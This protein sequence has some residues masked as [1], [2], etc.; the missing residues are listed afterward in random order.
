M[1][2]KHFETQISLYLD[3]VQREKLRK[4]KEEAKKRAEKEKQERQQAKVVELTDEEIKQ[5]EEEEKAKQ[6]KAAQPKVVE[7]EKKETPP[8]EGEDEGKGE[9]PLPG[10]GGKTDRYSWT[11]TLHELTVNFFIPSDVL[12][13]M[14]KVDVKADR[15]RILVRN[16]VFLEGEFSN[17][18]KPDDHVWTIDTV[19]GLRVLS[20]TVDKYE[21]TSWWSCVFKGDTEI[22]TRKVEP[23]NSKL[24]DLDEETRST[25][26]KMMED[27]RRK[28]M[29]LPSVDDEKKQD[30]LK[31]FMSAHPEMDFSK[32]KFS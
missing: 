1:L 27:Q 22:N 26:E 18:V 28:A 8:A 14:I 17:K 2:E 6:L 24:S 7:E 23:E 12:G 11:Q 16:A 31:Q 19:D 13:R 29:G 21:G 9:I 30:V 25:V 32:A 4:E 15:I 5:I 20:L 10:N 3:Q